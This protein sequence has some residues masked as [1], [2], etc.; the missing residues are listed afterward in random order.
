MRRFTS[1]PILTLPDS[2][3]PFVVEV[4]ASDVGV[5]AVLSQKATGDSKL[6]PCAFFHV[7]SPQ[8]K[9]TMTLVTGSCWRWNWRSRNGDTGW[10][11]PN[12]HSSFG[13]ITRTSHT[14][15][16][17]KG[18]IH[19]RPDGL[20][21]LIASSSSSLINQALRTLSPMPFRDSLTRQRWRTDPRPSFPAPRW[22]QGFS[23][24]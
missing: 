3:L 13:L 12:T 1:A 4:D 19:G 24:E 9:R 8:Q 2:E 23:G 6:H 18:W 14:S 11:E 15:G 16:R 20:S 21:F 22:W 7:E 5:G 17:L 10:K